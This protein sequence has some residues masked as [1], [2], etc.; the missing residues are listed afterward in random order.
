MK[1]CKLTAVLLCF[2]LTLFCSLPVFAA[3]AEISND[4]V[5]RVMCMARDGDCE[6]FPAGSVGGIKSCAEMGADFVSVGISRTADG[7][8]VLMRDG[9][10]SRY[11]VRGDGAAARGLVSETDYSALSSYRLLNIDR[12]V[13]EYAPATFE[14]ALDTGAALVLDGAWEYRDQIYS[15]AKLRGSLETVILRAEAGADEVTKW[16]SENAG[17]Q[18]IGVYSGNIVFTAAS[19]VNGLLDGG[20]EYVQLQSGNY[21]AVIYQNIV[22][23]RFGQRGRAVAAVYDK[24]LCGKRTDTAH[25]WDDLISRGYSVIETGQP[26]LLVS[27]IKELENEKASLSAL[28]QRAERADLTG[29]S[30]AGAGRLGEA[31]EDAALTLSSLCSREDIQRASAQLI[32]ALGALT[33]GDSA[34]TQ[35]NSLN[36][37]AG[38]IIAAVLGA[39]GV[40]L[41]Q[42]Y[43]HRRQRAVK[44]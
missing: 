27:Y 16:C 42:A 7:V 1:K 25:G 29:L 3:E 17:M 10:L 30:A 43:V 5:G 44:G 2:I 11:C 14:Q 8:L 6:S 21:F 18:V 19:Y 32:S 13:S 15:L 20:L 38:K 40:I 36:V 4:P 23:K 24:S 35:A 41:A 22:M 31:V 26:R 39:V 33:P 12:T 9:E 28:A 37:T 34:D